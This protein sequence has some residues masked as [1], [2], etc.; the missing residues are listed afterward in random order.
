MKGVILRINPEA[1]IVDLT[2]GIRPQDILAG[3]LTLRHAVGYF[4]CGTIHLAV[5]DPGVGSARRP[6]LVESAGSYFIGPDNGIFSLIPVNEDP[7]RIVELSNSEYH[8]KPTSSTFH[9]RD[10]FAPVAGH[11][12]LGIEPQCFGSLRDS[13]MQITLPKIV[14]SA[15]EIV[16]EIV[17][18]DGYGNLFTNIVERDLTVLPRDELTIACGPVTIRG[19]TK[20]YASARAGDYVALINS[21]GMLEIALR[22]GSAQ[23]AVGLSVGDQLKLT[24]G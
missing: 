19:L 23:R 9:G 15:R 10:I 11:L 14:R 22:N 6:L 7:T 13:M 1:R 20:S 4:P 17:Y 8:L 5:V 3:A 21:W 16:G 24:W 2:H 12:S 18:V